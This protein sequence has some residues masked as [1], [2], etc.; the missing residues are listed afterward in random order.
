MRSLIAN[1]RD[2]DSNLRRTSLAG[3]DGAKSGRE[4]SRIN[5]QEIEA[6]LA[7]L[8]EGYGKASARLRSLIERVRA[9]YEQKE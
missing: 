9:R 6:A 8:D 5:D 3:D 4:L 1:M 2:F 7:E